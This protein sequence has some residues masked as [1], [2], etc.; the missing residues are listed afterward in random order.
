MPN[1]AMS[2]P[3]F[4]RFESLSPIKRFALIGTFLLIMTLILLLIA[5]IAVRG[6]MYL[7][8]GTF[9]GFDTRIEDPLTG[10]LLPAPN[11]KNNNFK[12]N[13]AG[14]R[15]PE[16]D[17]KKEHRQLRLAFLGG[18]T[19]FSQEV[20]GN[21]NTWPAIATKFLSEKYPDTKIDYLNA[22][23]AALTTLDSRINIEKRVAPYSP[24]IV[25]IYHAINDIVYD[26]WHAAA[27]AGHI[28]AVDRAVHSP[29]KTFILKKSLLADLLQKN[30]TIFFANKLEIQSQKVLFEVENSKALFRQ[31]LEDLVTSAIDTA[32][33]VVLS[34]FTNRLRSGQTHEQRV[35]AMIS[36]SFSVQFYTQD[37][38]LIA[39]NS[40]NDVIRE[41]ANY[42]QVIVIDSETA[43]A[44]TAENFVDS[45]HFSA[46]GSEKFGKH[47]GSALVADAKVEQLIRSITG[48]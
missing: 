39:L 28:P 41:F 5:E 27:A 3:E 4:N 18:S 37:D 19:T 45:V 40:Y 10:M 2:P 14:F 7:K 43:I 12:I 23:A 6:R 34:T 15:S 42:E 17:T 32:P 1:P 36:H 26:A 48:Q 47:I 24:D 11:S 20:T 22:S 30:L 13:S 25:F 9:W 8:H 46:S 16:I 21:N 35:D 38:L 31:R 44:G 33:L 29:I